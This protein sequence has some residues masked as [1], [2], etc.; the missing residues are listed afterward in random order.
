[1]TWSA[2]V[3]RQGSPIERGSRDG[4]APYTPAS[5]TSCAF[6]AWSRRARFTARLG[7]PTPTKTTSPS[8]I[9]RAAVN[10][11]SSERVGSAGEAIVHRGRREGLGSEAFADR[12]SQLLDVL[13]P[14]LDPVNPLVE[15]GLHPFLRPPDVFPRHVELVVAIVVALNEARVSP[16][17]LLDHRVHDDPRDHRPVGIGADRVLMDDLLHHHDHF[18]RRESRFFLNSGQSP[19][20]GVSRGVAALGVK[21]GDV[22][23][24]RGNGVE[25]LAGEGTLDGPDARVDL[26][27]IRSVIGAKRK[28]RKPGGPRLDPHR[29]AEV[30]VLLDLERVRN[31][32]FNGPTDSVEGA[33]AGIPRPAEDELLRDSRGHH[34]VVDQIG[35]QPAKR[36]VFL[37]LP[38]DLVPGGKGDEVGEAFREHRVAVFDQT[39]DGVAHRRDFR[40]GHAAFRASSRIRTATS[41]SSSV[42]MSGGA[43]RIAL[44]PQP[45]RRRP[46]SKAAL[47][48]GS[49]SSFAGARL[50]RS[51]TRSI[52]SI[53]PSPR[54]SPITRCFAFSSS[55]LRRRCAPTFAAF[56]VS[57]SWRRS[58]VA[59]AAAQETAF[60]P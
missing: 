39:R 6:G 48:T 43:S 18:L 3:T 25:R 22:G 50:S 57:P 32:P 19:D 56:A 30:G 5:Y 24:Q 58:R 60:P 11:M 40:K 54:A 20:V 17:G 1:M 10:A 9:S 55:S 27:E 16:V 51:F 35:R 49:T 15:V 23:I 44:S 59:S 31:G 42:T 34:L 47:R 8:A 46:R 2:P 21:D 33:D 7:R 13:L 52:A 41:A 53:S 37:P 28:E 4:R 14:P 29:E 38:D 36:Q 12:P 26:R 45:R